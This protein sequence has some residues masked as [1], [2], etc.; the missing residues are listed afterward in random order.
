MYHVRQY[1]ELPTEVTSMLPE[2]GTVT[3]RDTPE[4]PAPHPVLLE[5][6]ASVARIL[7]M[8]AMGEQIEN[9][10]RDREEVHC[11]ASDG[12]TDLGYLLM[13]V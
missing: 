5:A 10:M 1:G 13:V 3:L 6:H 7:H 8:T 2:S 11:L 4:I 9:V 12:S